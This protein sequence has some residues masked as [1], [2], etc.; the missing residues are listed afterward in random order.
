MPPL[1]I[2]APAAALPSPPLPSTTAPSPPSSPPPA[3]P[4]PATPPSPLPAAPSP[5]APLLSQSPPPPPAALPPLPPLPPPPRDPPAP[6]EPPPAATLPPHPSLPPLS[7]LLAGEL[8]SRTYVRETLALRQSAAVLSAL[9]A[10]DAQLGAQLAEEMVERRDALLEGVHEAHALESKLLRHSERVEALSLAVR[11]AR[12]QF[13][14]PLERMRGAVERQTCYIDAME[15][16][17]HTQRS[18][19]LLRRLRETGV[20]EE[21]PLTPPRGGA[22]GARVDLPKAAALW[23]EL[24]QLR[25]EVDLRGVDV[26]DAEWA[27][28]GKAGEAIRASGEAALLRAVREQSQAQIGSALQIFFN[29]GTL[30]SATARAAALLADE[31]REAIV[32]S[33]TLAPAA[34]ADGGRAGQFTPGGVA[35][36][37]PPHTPA[38][39]PHATP[40]TGRASSSGGV[41]QVL[42]SVDAVAQDLT[43]LILRL[44]SLH[45]VLSRKRDPISHTLFESLFEPEE[46][47]ALAANDSTS[48]LEPPLHPLVA[49]TL[50]LSPPPAAAAGEADEGR[51][52]ASQRCGGVSISC[53]WSPLLA[54][55]REGF[56]EGM[57]SAGV[58]QALVHELPGVLHKLLAAQKH[59]FPPSTIC[60]PAPPTLA[61]HRQP[62]PSPTLLPSPRHIPLLTRPS[63]P[64]GRHESR[65]GVASRSLSAAAQRLLGAASLLE[66]VEAIRAQFLSESAA[67]LLRGVDAQVEVMGQ[68]G[69]AAGE[70]SLLGR[71]IAQELRRGMGIEPLVVLLAQ[72]AA[73]A[74]SMFAI[75]ADVAVR[76]DESADAAAVNERVLQTVA[77]LCA[78]VAAQFP[79]LPEQAA[80]QL[81]QGLEKLG[82]VCTSLA[83]PG[84]ALP[85]HMREQ[86]FAL[87]K[88]VLR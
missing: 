46:G 26:V 28:L 16:L 3:A 24:E 18:L 85:D 38:L 39:T 36:P 7:A 31:Y 64:R 50:A 42:A 61:P 19:H 56:G 41:Q 37:R 14:R 44:H 58:R 71:R 20:A 88:R 15:L 25:E 9:E 12:A 29:L 40:A 34:G 1:S 51:A 77:A 60:P 43:L 87:L 74:I 35:T 66:W 2:A 78:D 5:H 57:R 83:N 48:P 86:A 55:A 33:L 65:R 21:A 32:A 53:I 23:C 47:A 82:H 68:G 8:D 17:R 62:H 27:A 76:Q 4:P 59:L 13:C 6:R 30:P 84:V 75:K 80:Q 79:T 45:R 73:K 22:R 54:A 72:G 63:A 67:K 69:E 11:R 10:A 70:T 52:A 81:Q 49:A